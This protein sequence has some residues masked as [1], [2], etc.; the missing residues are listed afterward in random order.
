[1]DEWKK[2]V[3]SIPNIPG[4]TYIILLF[5]AQHPAAGCLET[6]IVRRKG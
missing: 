6:K 4:L 2:Y 5:Q 1:M 3:T